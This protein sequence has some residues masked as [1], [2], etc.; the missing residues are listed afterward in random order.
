MRGLVL[1]LESNKVTREAAARQFML[2][3]QQ[4]YEG[5]TCFPIKVP[6]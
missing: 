4:P 5:I 3:P 2:Q 1:V 6:Y